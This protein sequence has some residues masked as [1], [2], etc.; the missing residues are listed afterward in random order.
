MTE[1]SFETHIK[2]A[3]SVPTVAYIFSSSSFFS[4]IGEKKNLL[5]TEAARGALFIPR[6]E[7]QNFSQKCLPRSIPKGSSSGMICVIVSTLPGLA[8]LHVVP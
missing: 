3:K 4:P 5:T 8:D 7:L 2:A 1:K 6:D